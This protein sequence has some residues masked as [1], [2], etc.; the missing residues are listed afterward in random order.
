MSNPEAAIYLSTHGRRNDNH[1]TF[2]DYSRT[3]TGRVWNKHLHKGLIE[4]GFIQSKIDECVYYRG[5]LIYLCYVDD[6]WAC[7]PDKR[8]VNEFIAELKSKFDVTD[9]GNLNDFLGVNIHRHEDGSI[10]LTQ[11]HLIEQILR[12]LNFQ[13]DTKKVTT[14]GKP[15]QVLRKNEGAPEHNAEWEYRSIIGKMNFLEKST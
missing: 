15:D 8:D 9:E 5:E 7:A 4:L 3:F 12:D 13:R 11:P 14:P 2:C 10:E 1:R 6:S